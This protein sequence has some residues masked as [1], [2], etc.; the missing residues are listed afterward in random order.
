MATLEQHVDQW[1]HNR[2][3][4][5]LIPQTHPDW[6]ATLAFYSALQA[7]DALLASG[8]FTP[9]DHKQRN[10]VLCRTN[11][12]AQIWKHYSPL[13]QICRTVRYIPDP[14]QWVPFEKIEQTVLQG[15]LYKVEESVRN[16]LNK[17]AEVF[18]AFERIKLNV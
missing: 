15:Y 5:S 7:I 1:R 18:P 4:I 12:Y 9:K 8:G 17:E 3:L 11:T 13:Y 2:Q 6:I 16:L 14:T 10:D